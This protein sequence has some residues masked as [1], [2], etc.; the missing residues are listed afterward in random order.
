MIDGN[1]LATDRDFEAVVRAIE[2]ARELVNQHA[3]DGVREI[4]VMPRPQG[5]HRGVGGMR[6]LGRW[7]F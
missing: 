6:R 4:E 2:A 1:Y 5:D 3:F 7:G